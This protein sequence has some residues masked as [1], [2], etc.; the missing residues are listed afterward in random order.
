MDD[1]DAISKLLALQEGVQVVEQQTQ[2]MLPGTMG[3][4]NGC[5]GTRLTPCWVVSAP[6]FH[7]GIPCHN[8]CQRW[9]RAKGH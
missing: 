8:L 9:H 5:P 2:V 6:W 1:I 3:H 7:P 4:N